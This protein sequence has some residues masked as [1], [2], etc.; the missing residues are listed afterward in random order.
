MLSSIAAPSPALVKFGQ[1][2]PTLL[3]LLLLHLIDLT[4]Q[5]EPTRFTGPPMGACGGC[6]R[7]WYFFSLLS[8]CLFFSVGWVHHGVASEAQAATE[9]TVT[10]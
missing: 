6:G 4:A 9:K 7:R 8:S 2:A 3:P 10:D 5:T 1:T